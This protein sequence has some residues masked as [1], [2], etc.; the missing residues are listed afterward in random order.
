[1]RPLSLEFQA[2]GPYA[3]REHIDFA[4]LSSKGLLLI[5]GDTGSGK[6]MILD[7]MTQALYG[8]SSGGLRNE[9]TSLRCNRCNPD[10]DTFVEFIFEAGGKVY[11]FERRLEKKRVNL[12]EK[13]NISVLDDEGRFEPLLEKV[14]KSDLPAF[15]EKL[16]GLDYDQFTQVIILPQGKFERFLESDS[17]QK[18]EILTEIFGAGRW[19]EIARKYYDKVRAEYD[20]VQAIKE[21]V[22]SLLSSEHCETIEEL[23]H[24]TKD[25]EIEL[26]EL[27]RTYLSSDYDGKRKKLLADKETAGRLKELRE[28]LTSRT[29]S[30]GNAEKQVSARQSAQE[31]AEN[32]LAEHKKQES[33]KEEWIREK[34]ALESKF[35][36]YKNM[37]SVREDFEEADAQWKKALK[38]AESASRAQEQAKKAEA[39]A[40][41]A[42][43]E[44]DR[45]H[46]KV[47][48]A[49]ARGAAGRLAADLVE[50]EKCP[51][52]GSTHH[53]EPA[54]AGADAVSSEQVDRKFEALGAR[55]DEWEQA[56]KKTEETTR[57]A[58]QSRETC[59]KLENVRTGAEKALENSKAGMIDGIEDYHALE[60]RIR[61]L[62]K[63]ADA[64]DRQL[65]ELTKK[66]EE[67][68][69]SLTEAQTRLQNAQEEVV[70]ARTE[71]EAAQAK[72]SA[73]SDTF[74]LNEIENTLKTIDQETASY[75]RK[76]GSLSAAI[77]RL[78]NLSESLSGDME[79]Y[80]S[81]IA[82][83]ESALAFGRQLR[84]DAGVGLGRYVLGVMFDQVIYAANEML[85]KVHGG[86]YSLVR[87]EEGASG[88]RKKGLD[89]AVIDS[90]SESGGARPAASLSGG[91][92]FLVS[93]ALSI[94]MSTIARTDG[95]NIDAMFIDEGFGSLDES[96]IGDA[97]EVLES[98]RSSQG[99]GSF[100]GIISHVQILRDSIPSKLIV[101]K[102]RKT[103]SIE[104]T[105]G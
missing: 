22:S 76:Q 91:E 69:I 79:Q 95:I 50:G 36:I 12:S 46:K 73:E 81:R 40:L 93:L 71:V 4:D 87:T 90:F 28:I 23:N 58:E 41:A 96:S 37:E 35:D 3:G 33:E 56:R 78:A 10:D 86:R 24:K 74:D 6:T 82:K 60:K 88:S 70:K 57:S 1:M 25:A 43:E 66:A 100:V 27:S 62:Q 18:G 89:L 68:R 34:N 80:T 30:L 94:G 44:A 102:S 39:E 7:A 75:Q 103:S 11:K 13:L 45:Q 64:F 52:C 8:K 54:E 9:F 16:I 99:T 85:S 20:E 63:N 67:A 84:G 105:V 42:Y 101:H 97:L 61:F 51:V 104:Y 65:S 17:G 72:A 47:L 38:Q 32:H 92:K 2:F 19:D 55:H 31:E 59:A 14:R 5:C 26:E 29:N 53:P 15:A 83:A 48:E 21:R 77:E 49:F 98:I